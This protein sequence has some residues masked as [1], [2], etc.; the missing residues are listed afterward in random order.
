[1]EKKEAEEEEWA[2][3]EEE[4]WKEEIKRKRYGLEVEWRRHM[5]S[6]SVYFC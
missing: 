2:E 5:R 3:N 6:L 4:M 1:M